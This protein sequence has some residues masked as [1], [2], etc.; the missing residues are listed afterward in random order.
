MALIKDAKMN[1]QDIT[2]DAYPYNAWASTITVL[3]PS[4][5]HE[6]RAEIQK[7]IDAIG[8]ADKVLITSCDA[9]PEYEG[10]T[11]QQAAAIGKRS[12]IDTYIDDV[13]KRSRLYRTE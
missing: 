3:V 4:R 8:G 12:E 7:G 2:A 1:G 6:D 5:K 13:K 11:L 10:K 9:F